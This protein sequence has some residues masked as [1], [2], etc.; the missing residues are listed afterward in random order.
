MRL[1]SLLTMAGTI[2]FRQQPKPLATTSPEVLKDGMEVRQ[3]YFRP[4]RL[5]RPLMAASVGL[6]P[7]SRVSRYFV[8]ANAV[9]RSEKES[10][11]DKG[12]VL[13]EHHPEHTGAGNSL[14]KLVV[15]RSPKSTMGPP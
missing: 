15:W 6:I 2:L 9:Q 3:V 4:A 12:E 1:S 10:A 5:I 13:G 7:N 8:P 14:R 11:H